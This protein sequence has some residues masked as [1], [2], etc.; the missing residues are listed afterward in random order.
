MSIFTAHAKIIRKGEIMVGILNIQLKST[1]GNKELNLKKAESYIKQNSD[2]KTDLVVLPEF[3]ST[4]VDY[5]QFLNSPED[6]NGGEAI[7]FLKETAVKY[8]TN[9][10]AGTVIEKSGDKLYNTSFVINRKGEIVSKYRK[11]HLFN[12]MGGT[13]GERITP[14][15]DEVVV[16]LDFG[17]VGLGICFDMRY[18]LHFKK[19]V[20][21]GAEIIVVPTA[22]IVPNEIY[23]N[24]ESLRYARDIW[25]SMNKIRAYDNLV[26]IVSCNPSGRVDNLMGS[27]GNSLIVS[28]T[29]EILA[30]AK[31]EQCAIYADVDLELVKYYKSIYPIANID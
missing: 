11:I 14:G 24:S 15:E 19:L 26:Y 9:I 2:K 10:I 22:W 13:E 18:P 1:I 25:I 20:K 31:D 27:I 7:A 5:E 30:N 17:K 3:F 6:E 12:Y 8:K 23:D 21:M 4:G 29:T 28:P 16:D